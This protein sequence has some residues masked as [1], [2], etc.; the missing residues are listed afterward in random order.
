MST[1][2]GVPMLAVILTIASA[3]LANAAYCG[4]ANYGNCNCGA[5]VM[6]GSDRPATAL[7]AGATDGVAASGAA[8]SPGDNGDGT[9][10]ILVNRAR[11]VYVPEQYTAYR[12][13]HETVYDA[14]RPSTR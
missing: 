4:A 5:G 2:F 6:S 11:V 1:R 8:V 3:N 7:D 13:E 14:E 12:T 10:T 9:Y